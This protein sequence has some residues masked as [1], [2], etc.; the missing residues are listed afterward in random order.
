MHALG[1]MPLLARH[2]PVRLEPFI[3]LARILAHDQRPASLPSRRRN[4]GIVAGRIL[5]HGRPRDPQSPCY[6]GMRQAF[7][8][9]DHVWVVITRESI[10]KRTASVLFFRRFRFQP[11]SAS[12]MNAH[13]VQ[14]WG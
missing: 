3:G 2:A 7:R 10:R 13:T 4:R 9:E 5:D 8:F 6:L 12:N 14:I 1:D 11:P